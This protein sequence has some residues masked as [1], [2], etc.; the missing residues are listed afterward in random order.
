VWHRKTIIPTL[1]APFRPGSSSDRVPEQV[2]G[3]VG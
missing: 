3:Q 2:S 1:L